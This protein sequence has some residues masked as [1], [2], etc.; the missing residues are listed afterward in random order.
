MNILQD[1]NQEDILV[2]LLSELA[3]STNELRCA[4][5]DVE[6]AQNRLRFCV[7]A[8]NELLARNQ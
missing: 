1:K 5:Q 6:K 3:K 4:R 8:I 7:A 2:S